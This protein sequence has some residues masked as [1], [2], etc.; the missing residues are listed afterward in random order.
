MIDYFVFS[1]ESNLFL[2]ENIIFLCFFTAER[3]LIIFHFSTDIDFSRGIYSSEIDLFN[4]QQSLII[5]P[6]SSRQNQQTFPFLAVTSSS[7]NTSD[8]IIAFD[9]VFYDRSSRYIQYDQ[10]TFPFSG[11]VSSSKKL[12]VAFLGI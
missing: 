3:L 4:R 7:E 12:F 8:D 11:V 9:L 10:L 2:R 5:S 1:A 6:V